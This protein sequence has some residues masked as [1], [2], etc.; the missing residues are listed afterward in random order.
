MFRIPV[1][2]ILICGITSLSYAQDSTKKV[3]PVKPLKT[4]KPHIYKYHGA[5]ADSVKAKMAAQ[6]T[7]PAKP[8]SI[9]VVS[10]PPVVVDKSLNGQFQYLLTKVYHYQQPLISAL[11]K[12]ASDTLTSNRRKLQAAQRKIFIQGKAIDSLKAEVTSKSQELTATIDQRDGIDLLGVQL[13][14]TAYNAIVWGL[15]AAFGLITFVVIARTARFK[16]EARNKSALY[17]EL[18]EDFKAFKAKANDKEKKLARELQTE[19][20]KVDE[21]MGR[22]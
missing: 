16:H 1:I 12:N 8:D 2:A 6:Q 15:V 17:A 9:A 22:G 7:A 11:W 14:K 20:N 10:P 5:K 13:S 19:R 3:E 18:E 4:V 21:L